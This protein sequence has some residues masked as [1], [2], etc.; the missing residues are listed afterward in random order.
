MK[1]PPRACPSAPLR[2]S[3]RSTI[4]AMPS[5][6]TNTLSGLTLRIVLSMSGLPS[7]MAYTLALPGRESTEISVSCSAMTGADGVS[8]LPARSILF[9]LLLRM[10]C[11]FLSRYS[12]AR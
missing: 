3:R 10:S 2:L 1:V 6:L 9:S 12:I 5:A 8:S 7:G 11:R 4:R